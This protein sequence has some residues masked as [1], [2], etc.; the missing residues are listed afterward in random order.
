MLEL[1]PW[2]AALGDRV[3]AQTMDGAVSLNIPAGT[4]SGQKLRLK[5]KGLTNAK[6]ASGDQFVTLAIVT[7]KELT[8]QQRELYEQ[9]KEASAEKPEEAKSEGD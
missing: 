8:D 7:P 6:G 5:G 3:D 4:K 1:E 2:Q 9:L